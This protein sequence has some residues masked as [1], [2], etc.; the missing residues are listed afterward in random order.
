MLFPTFL[1]H[2]NKYVYFPVQSTDK[3]LL[4]LEGCH[5]ERYCLAGV[6]I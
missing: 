2:E 3:L 4:D 5:I 1:F 6:K